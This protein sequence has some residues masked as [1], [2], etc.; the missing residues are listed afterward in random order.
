MVKKD[1]YGVDYEKMKESASSHEATGLLPRMPK[2]E[3]EYESYLNL[4]GVEYPPE[5]TND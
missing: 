5:L 2:T 4:F 3:A 1:R